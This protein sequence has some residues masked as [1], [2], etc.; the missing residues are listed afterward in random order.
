MIIFLPSL[1]TAVCLAS[2]IPDV[3][4]AGE[5][6]FSA[7]TQLEYTCDEGFELDGESSTIECGASGEWSAPPSCIQIGKSHINDGGL[8]HL[9]ANLQLWCCSSL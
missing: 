5:P 3:E 8:S 9:L 4:N 2:N 6:V 1:A 7:G